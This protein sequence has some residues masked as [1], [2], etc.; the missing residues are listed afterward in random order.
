M[1]VRYDEVLWSNCLNQMKSCCGSAKWT[2]F[3]QV[4]PEDSTWT[5]RK[6][7]FVSGTYLQA[8]SLLRSRNAANIEIRQSVCRSSARRSSVWTTDPPNGYRHAYRAAQRIARSK[9]SR[10]AHRSNDC[11]LS[12][13]GMSKQRREANRG[14]RCDSTISMVG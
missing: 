4:D 2:R 12:R 3:V 6:A 1:A 8:W 13:R 10:V 9:R 14:H 5:K 7:P 11:A